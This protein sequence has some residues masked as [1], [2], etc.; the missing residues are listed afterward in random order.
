MNRRRER[1]PQQRAEARATR[2]RRP[3]PETASSTAPAAKGRPRG[4]AADTEFA[5]WLDRVTAPTAEA[6]RTIPEIASA[7]GLAPNSLW[8][9]RRGRQGVSLGV[10]QRL[11]EYSGG[12]LT[13]ESFAPSAGA[14]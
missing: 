6:R 11:I 4:E 7:V 10:V 12:E 8:S 14:R 5:R 9:I 13:I 3:P 2:R 1:K